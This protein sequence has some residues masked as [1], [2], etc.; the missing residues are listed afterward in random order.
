MTWAI[1]SLLRPVQWL[2]NS[3]FKPKWNVG[4]KP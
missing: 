4:G 1:E 3:D 2:V